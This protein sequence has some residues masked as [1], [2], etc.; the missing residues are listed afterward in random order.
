MRG[1]LG[2]HVLEQQVMVLRNFV[3][4]HAQELGH[5]VTD[6]LHTGSGAVR[7]QAVLV[8]ETGDATGDALDEQQLFTQLLVRAVLL[9]HILHHAHVHHH[10]IARARVP[11]A[12][13]HPAHLAIGTS[14]AVFHI[15][16]ITQAAGL[17]KH[18]PI[19]GRNAA[20]CALVAQP[21]L[22][23]KT[24]DVTQAR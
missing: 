13:T 17:V 9:G 6:V 7:M 15:R 23:L 5:R 19:F 16:A 22:P 21:F 11:Y 4:R 8:N 20:D 12:R 18:G 14:P 1:V 24:R 3:G 2:Q 10:A